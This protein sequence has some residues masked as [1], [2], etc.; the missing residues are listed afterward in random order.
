MSDRFC[1]KCNIKHSLDQDDINICHQM[2]LD[3]L[4]KQIETLTV[5]II[6]NNSNNKTN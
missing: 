5:M 2:Q 3:C 1:N 6:R 4:K